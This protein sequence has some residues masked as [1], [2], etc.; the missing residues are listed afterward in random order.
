[1]KD[2]L[3]FLKSVSKVDLSEKDIEL[4]SLWSQNDYIDSHTIELLSIHKVHHIFLNHLLTTTDV[5]RLKNHFGLAL[6]AQLAFLQEKYNENL[7]VLKKIVP[8][9]EKEN[10]HYCVIKGFSII[11][12]LYSK[13]SV[14]SRDFGD[15]DFLIEKE[16]VSKVNS[17]MERFGFIQGYI[18]DKYTIE[19]ASRKD[20][21]YWR[22]NSHQEHKYIGKSEH[23]NISPWLYNYID[24]NV[25][26][27]EGGKIPIPISTEE[28]MLHTRQKKL[29]NNISI[30]CLDYTYEFF[31]LCYSFYKDTVYLSKKE[32]HDNYCLIKFCDLRE[33]VLKYRKEIDWNEFIAIVNRHKLGN[34]IYYT[35]F[36]VSSFYGDLDIDNIISKIEVDKQIFLPH[37][38]EILL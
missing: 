13:N 15:I 33:Y 6:S 38:D 2:Y 10:I 12:S 37:W 30:I 3:E 20:I 4:I 8:E 22:L 27:F 24:V 36:L 35:L 23:S 17:I 19:K 28:I 25:T 16:N 31:Q 29:S 32:S 1:M 34:Q 14:V 21:L 26:I 18:T 11:D 5:S 7:C 9:L